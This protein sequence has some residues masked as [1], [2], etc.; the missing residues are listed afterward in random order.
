MQMVSIEEAQSRLSEIIEQLAPEQEVV[1]TRNDKP[2]A[3]IRGTTSPREQ[4][5]RQLGTLKGTVLYIAPDFDAIPEGFE[6]YLE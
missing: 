2:V 6:E 4:K 5:P 1:I 3:T